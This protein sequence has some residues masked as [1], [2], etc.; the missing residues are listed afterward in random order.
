MR[1]AAV[2]VIS[3]MDCWS[4]VV[5]LTGKDLFDFDEIFGQKWTY[6]SAFGDY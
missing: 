6:L 3:E 4:A 1:E 5:V 2:R